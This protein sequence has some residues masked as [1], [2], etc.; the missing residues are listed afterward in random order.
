M[1][2]SCITVYMSE[3]HECGCG[4]LVGCGSGIVE[5]GRHT[6]TTHIVKTGSGNENRTQQHRLACGSARTQCVVQ[7]QVNA[8]IKEGEMNSRHTMR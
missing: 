4:G 5:R 1:S 6:N 3:W 7:W 2:T 8:V